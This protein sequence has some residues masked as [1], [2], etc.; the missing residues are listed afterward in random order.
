MAKLPARSQASILSKV[1]KICLALPE[2][3]ERLSHGEPTFFFREK[4]SFLNMDTYHHGSD[5]Y[6]AWVAA[7]LGAQDVLVR[8]DPDRFFVPPYVGHRGWV[9]IVLDAPPDWDEIARIVADAY[10][11]VS[12]KRG[13]T[14]KTPRGR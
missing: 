11:H 7:P 10:E 6:S 1:R 5:H 13:K 3:S 9:G 8:S 14:T 12:G 4:K 2:T